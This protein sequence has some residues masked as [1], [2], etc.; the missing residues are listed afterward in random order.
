MQSRLQ[1]IFMH[2][3]GIVTRTHDAALARLNDG[4]PPIVLAEEQ[5]NREE[6]PLSVGGPLRSSLLAAPQ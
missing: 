6:S 5:F 4:L 2:I 3:V 1:R